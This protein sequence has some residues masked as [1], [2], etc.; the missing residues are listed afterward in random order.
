MAPLFH[1]VG[2]CADAG[3]LVAV[4]EVVIYEC[5]FDD[6]GATAMVEMCERFGRYR[7]Y[8][9]LEQ[10]DTDIG[11]GLSQRHDAVTNFLRTG[12]LSA[13]D[14]SV[15]TLAARTSYFREE[16]A[17]G[18]RGVIDGI[19]PFLHHEGFLEAARRVHGRA[20]IEPA[21]AYANLMVPG[22]ELAVH[23]DVP[24][25]RGCN[26]KLMPQWLLV[27]MHHSGLFEE[28]RL[29][30]ATGIAWFHDCDGGQLVY[31]PDGRDGPR[32]AHAVRYN[33]A[34]V[35]DT[36]SVFH[37]VDRIADIDEGSMPRLRPGM[38][39]DFLGDRRWCVRTPEGEPLAEYTWPDLR[40]SVS[41]KAYC[42]HD[43]AERDA[44]RDHTD[45][46]GIDAVLDRL[47]DDLQTR[48][49]VQRDVARDAHLGLQLIDEYVRFPTAAPA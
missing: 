35:L 29:P 20:V 21:I 31:W 48:G 39:L 1:A 24:E 19:E 11:R 5:L 46:L 27:V 23:T 36:D 12:G 40:F 32:L 38:T 16:Y 41:W 37:G 14:E 26:R 10:L 49:R 18:Q 2:T 45:D 25:F 6:A 7:M 15:L 43:D 47:I 42:F 44:W 33:S 9:E 28:W 3:T 34:M 4:S 30:I 22:Q 17:Y 13:T 8:A